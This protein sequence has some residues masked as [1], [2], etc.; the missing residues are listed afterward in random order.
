MAWI[1]R[2]LS[3][4]HTYQNTSTPHSIFKRE[5]KQKKTSL[6]KL[7]EM[8]EKYEKS[9]STLLFLEENIYPF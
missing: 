1:V 8:G 5:L 4:G 9:F 7:L 2:A 6:R 3:R